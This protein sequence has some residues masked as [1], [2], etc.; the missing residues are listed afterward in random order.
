MRMPK[1]ILALGNTGNLPGITYPGNYLF[2]YPASL[3][4]EVSPVSLPPSPAASS[5]GSVIRATGPSLVSRSLI[6]IININHLRE[7][8]EV[9]VAVNV[10]RDNSKTGGLV[11]ARGKEPP[12]RDGGIAS[13]D[14]GRAYRHPEGGP[15]AQHQA[16]VPHRHLQIITT[17]KW[18]NRSVV[19]IQEPICVV[20]SEKGLWGVECTLAVIGTGG[21]AQ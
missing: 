11:H 2:Y 4:A 8:G 12:P 5:H 7:R 20:L 17:L 18:V 21:P 9:H 14:G 3:N 13:G 15:G 10:P 16:L 6:I 19:R 1:I